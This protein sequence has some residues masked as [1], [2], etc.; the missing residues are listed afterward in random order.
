MNLNIVPCE[1]DFQELSYS[2]EGACA[3][4]VRAYVKDTMY[5]NPGESTLVSLGFKAK[6]PDG[7]AALLL[8]RS[9]LGVKQGIVLGNL[10]GLI[11]VD[12]YGLWQAC[13]WNRNHDGQAVKI[14]RG[15]RV[16]QV[17]IVP[18]LKVGFNVVE[19]LD[20]TERGEAGFGTS[21]VK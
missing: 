11:D 12:Y 10:V 17:M 2:T 4:D 1:T 21:G 14:E 6:V 18:Y 15:D 5:L 20:T 16:G 9:G 13:L 3:F 19:S 8:P 7:H